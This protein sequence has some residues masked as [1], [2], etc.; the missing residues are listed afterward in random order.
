MAE[1]LSGVRIELCG[2]LRVEI[3]GRPRL[4]ATRGRQ[5]RLLLAYLVLH[6][7]TPARRDDLIHVLWPGEL[8]RDPPAALN[9]LLSRLRSSLGAEL[10]EGRRELRLNL[11]PAAEVDVELAAAARERAWDALA[12][13]EL[14]EATR[15][16]RSAAEIAERPLLPG[17]EAPWLDRARDD[18]AATRADALEVL[19]R[20]SLRGGD[21]A[22]ATVAAA[23]LVELEPFREPGYELLMQAQAARGN[24]AEALRV[25]ERLRMLLRTELGT[26]PARR[27][28]ELHTRLLAHGEEAQGAAP[29]PSAD[30]GTGAVAR[31]VLP[32]PLT[33]SGFVG[34]AEPLAHLAS[35]LTAATS[36]Q[37]RVALLAGEPGI[38]KTSLAA[39]FARRAHA[40]GAVVLYG[41]CDEE[42]LLPHQPFVEALCHYVQG[43]PRH[44]LD[45][46]ANPELDALGRLMP[47]LG[48][49]LLE[50]DGPPPYEPETL[51]YRMFEA[52]VALLRRLT[53]A[54]PLVLILDDLHWTDASSLLL[55]RHVA[56]GAG[57]ARLVIV[58]AYRDVEVTPEHP[59]TRLL[60]DLRRE[61]ALE[62]LPLTGLDEEETRTF[63]AARG[64]AEDAALSGRLRA[65]TAGN[66]LFLDEMLR[67]LRGLRASSSPDARGADVLAAIGV[68]EGAEALIAR[69]LARLGE[70]G[71]EVLA[72]AAVLGPSFDLDV[73]E[74]L[75]DGLGVD[76]L[77]VIEHAVRGGLLAEDPETGERFTFTHALV[78]DALLGSMT[79]A[80]RQR[81][82]A[83]A[84]EVLEAR[85]AVQ[86]AELAHH[87]LA[88]GTHGS[89]ERAVHHA[90]EAAEHALSALAYEEAAARYDRALAALPALGPDDAERRCELL[91][92]R[93]EAE[94]QA[95]APGARE[96]FAAAAELARGRRPDLLARAAMGFGGRYFEAG[97]VETRFIALLEEAIAALAPGADVL[98]ASLLGRLAE[99]LHWAGQPE[100]ALAAGAR[101]VATARPTGDDEALAGALAGQHVALL[102]V[103]H[104]EDRL[105]VSAEWIAL[106]ARLARREPAVHAHHARIYDLLELGDAQ[107]AQRHHDELKRLAAEL[108]QPV[109]RHFAWAWSAMWAQTE[110]RLADAERIGQELFELQAR[111]GFRDAESVLAARLFA[112]RRDQGRLGELLPAV[113]VFVA[114]FPQFAAWR[115]ALPLVCVEAG[116]DERARRELH[117]VAA[118]LG[119]VPRDF[120]WLTA[121]GV[122]GEAAAALG[123][124]PIAARVYA[125]LEPFAERT[126]Q[127]GFAACF[128]PVERVLGVLAAACG[129]PDAAQAHLERALARAEA[130]GALTFAL[131]SRAELGELLLERG[132]GDRDRALELLSGAAAGAREVGMDGVAAHAERRLELGARGAA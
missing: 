108:G 115:A 26:A 69:R 101:A 23:Q 31:P 95:G 48:A 19:A 73:L 93:G 94:L 2:Q 81:L 90:V 97:V 32:R 14:A 12:R 22:P 21:F 77:A 59:L 24:V 123:D 41:R 17:D 18:L 118:G 13:A 105:T 58:G 131:R 83:R 56:R 121:V 88:A 76:V 3:G 39:E 85:M 104:L 86:P 8:P 116:D 109:Y 91:L 122:V 89:P 52:V 107:G 112:I 99:A 7:R 82:H 72:R 63:V 126:V 87:F 54:G 61:V 5:S 16:A 128:G 20:A 62:H 9:T 111:L 55:L 110:G 102:H 84:G 33:G 46:F 10:L 47:D 11:G 45:P 6:R 42:T 53:R 64:S 57:L 70:A 60:A 15:A 74:P 80:R 35:L 37:R 127:L 1:R 25:F 43:S 27:L 125:M 65:A 44:E 129:R 96:T 34:R 103:A 120:F 78:R 114:Q 92:A 68:P 66:P 28:L 49:R 75:A 79:R 50:G 30:P 100:R 51:R 113:D 40:A 124:A 106:A 117:Q 119:A 67:N 38:G 36:G 130:T 98:R 132:A 71:G 29:A 4:E